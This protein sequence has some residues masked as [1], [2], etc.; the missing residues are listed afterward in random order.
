MK[1]FLTGIEGFDLISNGGLPERRTTLVAGTSGSSKTV[2]AVQFLVEGIFKFDQSGVFV[3]FEET[4]DEIRKNMNGF[5]WDIGQLEDEGKWAFVD[6][7]PN[8]GEPA[9]VVGPFDFGALLA[10]IEH[11]V[12]KVGA[13]RLSM[14]S[15][16]AVFTQFSDVAIVRGEI[17]RIAAALKK[18]GVTSVLTAERIEEYGPIARFGVEEFVS[19][20]VVIV[21]NV[22]EG[23]KTAAD[24]GDP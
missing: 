14:D 4:P 20:N 2:F 16:G 9:E 22:L 7:S 11:A 5:G 24:H 21:R 10:R 1:S 8:P 19:D 12:K 17:F 13:A 15:L 18:L 23:E 3:T 6:A